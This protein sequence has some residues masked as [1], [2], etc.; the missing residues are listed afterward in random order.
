MVQSNFGEL[1][2]RVQIRRLLLISY[3]MKA[4]ESPLYLSRKA[5]K[6]KRIKIRRRSQHILRREVCLFL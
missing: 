2:V 5:F 4:K 1:A 6:C 3:R